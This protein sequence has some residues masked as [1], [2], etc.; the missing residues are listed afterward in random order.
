MPSDTVHP[1]SSRH[2]TSSMRFTTQLFLLMTMWVRF[3]GWPFLARLAINWR[4]SSSRF[5][6]ASAR[7]RFSRRCSSS[8]RG[9]QS[10]NF[11]RGNNSE[12]RS[13]F[14]VF[15]PPFL[16]IA[17]L[18]LASIGCASTVP[19]AGV[20]GTFPSAAFASV[21][22]ITVRMPERH[23]SRWSARL[24]SNHRL[25]DRDSE[26]P[27]KP[28][29]HTPTGGI[30]SESHASLRARTGSPPLPASGPEQALNRGPAVR[31]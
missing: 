22:V 6:R 27:G 11:G 3:F 8:V 24:E 16:L 10:R 30:V 19:A 7:A 2:A 21:S 25:K 28:E 13:P 20:E 12:K 23:A 29:G 31:A 26:D 4:S 5:S 17:C 15:V 1:S 14:S 18:A 9:S